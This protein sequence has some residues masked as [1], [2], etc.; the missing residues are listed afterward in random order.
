MDLLREAFHDFAAILDTC[1]GPSP[2]KTQAESAL[3]ECAMW[4]NKAVTHTV[5]AANKE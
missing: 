4:M 2:W 1:A 3:E 5:V